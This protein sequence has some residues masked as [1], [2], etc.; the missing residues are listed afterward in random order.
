MHLIMDG[1]CLNKVVMRD[2]EALSQWLHDTAVVA[3]MTPHG[4]PFIDGFAWPGSDDAGALSGVQFLKESAIMVHTWPEVSYAFVDVFSCKDFDVQGMQNH[5]I[6]TLGMGTA[7][8]LVLERGVDP[9]T[10]VIVPAR[11][12]GK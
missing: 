3:G 2:P 6:E 8:V 10:G 11:L 4:K 5:I 7:D 1:T 12:R 9:T